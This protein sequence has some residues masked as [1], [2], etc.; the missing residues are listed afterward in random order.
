VP[1]WEG[2]NGFLRI[3]LL[4]IKTT[5]YAHEIIY[6]LNSKIEI[7]FLINKTTSILLP[8]LGIEYSKK[9]EPL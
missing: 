8:I 4:P 5:F 9:M 2:C 3:S 1:E 6:T 7:T